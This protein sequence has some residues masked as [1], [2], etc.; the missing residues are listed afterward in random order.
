[1]KRLE[2]YIHIPFCVKKCDYCDFLSAPSGEETRV[3]YVEALKNEIRLNKE[4]MDEYV[5]DTVFF[6]GGTPSILEGEQIVSIMDVLRENAAISNDAEITIECNPG[7]VTEQKLAQY[8]KA[9]INRISF[10]L[11]SANNDELRAIGRIHTFEEFLESYTMAREAGFANINVDLMSALPGQDVEKYKETVLKVIALKPE[12]ISSYSLIVEEGTLME[13]RVEEAQKLGKDILP[14]EDEERKMYHLTKELLKASGYE[15]YEISNYAKP[16]KEC[17]HNMGY[18]NRVEYLG[19]GIGAAS[20]YK[21][22]RETNI[23]DISDYTNKLENWTAGVCISETNP[24]SKECPNIFETLN[25]TENSNITKC[26]N[27]TECSN[28]TEC[29]EAGKL[30]G[31]K[32]SK[33]LLSVEEQM[34]EFMFLGLRLMRGISTAEFEGKFQVQYNRIYGPIVEKLKKQSLL[35]VEKDRIWL[36]EKGIDVSN[37]VMSEFIL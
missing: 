7:T 17:R 8:K 12:H 19:F 28:I 25:I 30:S 21:E 20:L 3:R 11:Q 16:G 15:R 10:G 4:R 2:I 31:I 37:Y 24:E 5:V 32:E 29:S 35:S 14:D 34:E 22:E 13:K 18:W 23:S 27:V 33:Q 1:M 6:G 36:T 26:P 9:G